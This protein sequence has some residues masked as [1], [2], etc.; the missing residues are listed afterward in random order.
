MVKNNSHLGGKNMPK[1][2]LS[3][4]E[5]RPKARKH[6]KTKGAYGLN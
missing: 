5:R 4:E 3:A 6:R 1:Y 2:K